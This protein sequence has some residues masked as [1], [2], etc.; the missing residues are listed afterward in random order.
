MV[1]LN[2]YIYSS[3]NWNFKNR[4]MLNFF[5]PVVTCMQIESIGELTLSQR[6]SSQP[7]TPI[8]PVQLYYAGIR[9]RDLSVASISILS[10][11]LEKSSGRL[12]LDFSSPY[13]QKSRIRTSNLLTII[14]K[15]KNRIKFF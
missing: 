8:L 6:K 2:F 3:I 5:H 13:P 15:I 4:R 9:T 7:S 10:E 12:P 14:S 1:H 11:P